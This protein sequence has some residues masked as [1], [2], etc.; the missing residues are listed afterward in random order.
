MENSDLEVKY[1]STTNTPFVNWLKREIRNG[2]TPIV[3]FCGRQRSGKTAT[4]MRFAYEIYPDKFSFENVTSDV[5]KFVEL[6]EKFD[7][8]IIILDEASDS[9]YVYDW[10]SL[11]QKVFST[12]NDTQAYKQNIVFLILPMVHKLGK[13][14]R[15]DVDGI[16]MTRKLRNWETKKQEI[17]YKYQIHMKQYNDL[18]MR[19]PRVMTILDWCGP[20]PLPPP[21][22]WDTYLSEGQKQFKD[23][24]MQKNLAAMLKKKGP[25]YQRERAN[26]DLKQENRDPVKLKIQ[27]RT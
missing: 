21:H 11:F 1:R 10:N 23:K 16:I 14:H 2:N 12:I 4:A 26:L 9:L 27:P 22:I 8:N 19:P 17:Y 15:Y 3:V 13:I 25:K 7:H 6:Y 18:T 20:V 24:I 5:E